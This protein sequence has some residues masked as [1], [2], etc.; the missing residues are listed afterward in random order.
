MAF[1]QRLE[2]AA[3][4]KA[5]QIIDLCIAFRA[6]EAAAPRFRLVLAAAHLVLGLARAFEHRLGKVGEVRDYLPRLLQLFEVGPIIL[7]FR[8]EEHPSEI[9]SL[10]RNSY[11]VF[12]LENKQL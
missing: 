11:S 10:M 2:G 8:S 3:V 9:Q 6:R 5:G 1:E 4:G 7:E 12:Y